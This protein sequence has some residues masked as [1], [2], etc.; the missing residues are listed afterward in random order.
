MSIMNTEIKAL[1]DKENV[2]QKVTELFVFTDQRDW[3]KVRECFTENVHFDMTSMAGGD[4]VNLTP[5]QIT[6]AW[7]EGLKPLQA[8]HHQV[9]NF[10][11]NLDKNEAEVFCYGIALHYL[12]NPSGK[13]TRTFV[14]S[15]DFHLMRQQDDW[16]INKFKFNL[17]Y[18][19]GNADLGS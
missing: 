17:K 18:I 13:N 2:I 14:G 4:P 11:V 12:E 6:Q 7:D 10:M 8:I 3:S 16:K 5:E 19:D 15:Y 9:G 1:I